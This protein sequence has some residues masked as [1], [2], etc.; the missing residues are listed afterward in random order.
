MGQYG[1]LLRTNLENVALFDITPKVGGGV[2]GR[3]KPKAQWAI[4][5]DGIEGFAE[6]LTP[7]HDYAYNQIFIGNAMKILPT[8][9]DRS[10]EL[11]LAIDII[12]HLDKAD[13]E[14]F[15]HHL[16]RI[17]SRMALISTPKS[18]I[19][20]Q[21]EANPLEDH[22]SLWSRDD[23]QR[24]GFGNLVADEVSWIGCSLQAAHL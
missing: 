17:A 7:V 9:A 8:I 24:L 13:G 1:F 18:F 14:F 21:V 23:L 4:T 15:A 16:R 5:I 11:V 3:R 12:E 20:Q 22:R 2:E 6:Y 10:Y 19:E